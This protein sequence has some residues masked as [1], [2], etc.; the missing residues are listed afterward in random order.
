MKTN[1]LAIIAF[2]ILGV[3]IMIGIGFS[4]K[5]STQP[6]SFPV[7]LSF[8]EWQTVID[9]VSDKPYKTSAPIIQKIVN[10]VNNQ[11]AADTIKPKK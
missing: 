10:Q 4:Q 2:S 7:I 9:A 5:P 1:W 11:I 3:F 8:E 6:K